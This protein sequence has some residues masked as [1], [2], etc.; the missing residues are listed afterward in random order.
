MEETRRIECSEDLLLVIKDYDWGYPVFIAPDKSVSIKKRPNEVQAT[1]FVKD[2]REQEEKLEHLLLNKAIDALR[3]IY[4]E[5]PKIRSCRINFEIYYGD[6]EKFIGEA[7][8]HLI[9]INGREY[10][11]S[12]E[13][14]AWAV[15]FE[16]KKRLAAKFPELQKY[17]FV[18]GL[19]KSKKYYATQLRIKLPIVNEK[20]EN[21]VKEA[22]KVV[23]ENYGE[24]TAEIEKTKRLI[25][26]KEK[27]IEFLKER[28]RQLEMQ[29]ELEKMKSK[30]C[31]ETEMNRNGS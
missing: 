1:F 21:L 14:Q 22:F 23:K 7:T 24:L 9:L 31:I 13:K 4:A 30:L 3:E 18:R 11:S 25:Q 20:L 12:N 29:M 5:E 10:E 8:G 28:L 19:P 6:L 27:E 26:E 17:V 15:S 2:F 16:R